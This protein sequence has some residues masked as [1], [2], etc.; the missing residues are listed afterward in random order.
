[1]DEKGEVKFFEVKRIGGTKKWLVVELWEEGE[2]RGPF[3]SEEEALNTE[4]SL[5]REKGWGELRQV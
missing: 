3:F 4:L 2:I 1:M 5:G